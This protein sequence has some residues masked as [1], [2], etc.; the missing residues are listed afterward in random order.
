MTRRERSAG[1]KH[2]DGP[3]TTATV[4]CFGLVMEDRAFRRVR[5]F[6]LLTT[7]GHMRPQM[8]TTETR[9]YRGYKIVPMRQWASW[10]AEAFPTR[11]DLPFLTQFPLRTLAPSKE[12]AVAEVKQSIDRILASVER[13]H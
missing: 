11:A 12:A 8:A 5:V 1:S 13:G 3:R 4:L 7:G 10:C 2:A 6:T 9:Q